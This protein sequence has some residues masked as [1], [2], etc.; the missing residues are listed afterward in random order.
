MLR[1]GRAG[2]AQCAV[3]LRVVNRVPLLCPFRRLSDTSPPRYSASVST[4]GRVA[5]AASV[6]VT[7]EACI[8]RK[9]PDEMEGGQRD[10]RRACKSSSLGLSNP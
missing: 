2:A 3:V 4:V 5:S 6:A 9:D 8:P 10:S 1:A 7:L